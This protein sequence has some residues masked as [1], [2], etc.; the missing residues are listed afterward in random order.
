VEEAEVEADLKVK[1]FQKVMKVFFMFKRKKEL[2]TLERMSTIKAK[3]TRSGILLTE[4]QELV[5]EE[6]SLRVVMVKET[7]AS[8]VMN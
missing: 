4:D 3:E 7:G 1:K 6:R 2:I 5:E 8:L